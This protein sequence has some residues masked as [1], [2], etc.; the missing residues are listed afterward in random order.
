MV[1][2][3]HSYLCVQ[4]LRTERVRPHYF[5]CLQSSTFC[6]IHHMAIRVYK[7]NFPIYI[8]SLILYVVLDGYKISFIDGYKISS[9][10]WGRNR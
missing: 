9:F 2:F 1:K 8:Y 4:V 6:G 3:R 7:I 10:G 5:T